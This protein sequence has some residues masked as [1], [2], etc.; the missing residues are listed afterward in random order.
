MLDEPTTA[1]DV[2]TQIDV[3]A[4]IKHA[5]RETGTAALYISHDLAIVAQISDDIMVLRH[6]RMVEY[7]T[8]RQVIEAPK[9]T[10]TRAL[11]GVSKTLKEEAADQSDC[12]L[13]VE[14]VS[15]SYGRHPVLHD[16]SLHVPRGQTLAV[17][18]ESGSGKSTL[19]RVV[20]GLLPPSA[21]TVLLDGGNLSL[22]HI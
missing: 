6:G 16:I 22:I 7:G 10:Y 1:L 9:E 2:T 12:L 18:G 20:A 4:A 13:R 11:V 19:A 14:N 21:G 17:V 8:A 15:A 3:L 5:I